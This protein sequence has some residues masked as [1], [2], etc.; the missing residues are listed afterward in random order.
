MKLLP[1]VTVLFSSMMLL[2][3]CKTI[4]D[5]SVPL[6]T[7]F[8]TNADVFTLKQPGPLLTDKAYEQQSGPYAVSQMDISWASTEKRT[9]APGDSA[10]DT[11]INLLFADIDQQVL[12]HTIQQRQEYKFTS[13]NGTLNTQVYC[14]LQSH[15]VQQ[16]EIPRGEDKPSSVDGGHSPDTRGA[17]RQHTQLGC[18]LTQGDR[19]WQLSL[20]LQQ[21]QEPVLTLQSGNDRYQLSG[22]H[23]SLQKID[24]QWQQVPDIGV[25]FQGLQ[26]SNQGQPLAALSLPGKTPKIWLGR[27]LTAEQQNILFAA[28]YSIQMM[29]WLDRDWRIDESHGFH[30]QW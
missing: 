18:V 15:S 11:V 30:Q 23:H 14:R 8:L 12:R 16:E 9:Q 28:S 10:V 19:Q 24:N 21:Q 1:P 26:I 13:G 7:P 22:I 20:K 25:N 29:N 17:E 27:Q 3:G 6:P 4:S 5:Y 2:S